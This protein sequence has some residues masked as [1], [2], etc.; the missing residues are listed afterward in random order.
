M[1]EG[2]RAVARPVNP[3]TGGVAFRVGSKLKFYPPGNKHIPTQGMFGDNFRFT[4]VGYAG[5]LGVTLYG[6]SSPQVGPRFFF[7]H[8]GL[9]CQRIIS[10]IFVGI[11][12]GSTCPLWSLKHMPGFFGT[13]TKQSTWTCLASKW[14]LATQFRHG[15]SWLHQLETFCL[16]SSRDVGC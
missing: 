8:I 10:G 3:S 14:C 6:Q 2:E 11:T 7:C 5:F 13:N 12:T 15:F 4:K 9:P 16:A 1:L